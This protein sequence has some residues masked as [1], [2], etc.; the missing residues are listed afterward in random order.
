MVFG[1]HLQYWPF[2]GTRLTAFGLKL[3]L[4]HE[5]LARQPAC[6]LHQILDLPCL[7]NHVIQFLKVNLFLYVHTSFRFCFSGESCLTQ[8]AAIQ[9]TP[10]VSHL[11]HCFSDPDGHR[12]LFQVQIL[13]QQIW[14]G[15]PGFPI[16]NK[17]PGAAG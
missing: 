8:G 15:G 1:L 14:D 5:S 12:I 7:H 17:L 16:S 4:F 9:F 2:L 6:L 10:P 13:I 11:P 3:Q